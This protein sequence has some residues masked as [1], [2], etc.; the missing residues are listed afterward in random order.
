MP[1]DQSRS[2][3]NPDRIVV[4]LYK[5]AAAA[6]VGVTFTL[7]G[8]FLGRATIQAPAPTVPY[9]TPV[10]EVTLIGAFGPGLHD[11]QI[12]LDDPSRGPVTAAAASFDGNSFLV[13][14]A[15]SGAAGTLDLFPHPGPQ[16]PVSFVLKYPF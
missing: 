14:A 11:L 9:E 7:D 6:P 16:P 8:R 10:D 13:G 12:I 2:T 4:D 3:S 1:Y 5:Q 15:S